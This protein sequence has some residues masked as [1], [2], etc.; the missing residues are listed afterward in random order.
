[1]HLD[2]EG[3]AGLRSL[4]G[5]VA[6]RR[7]VEQKSSASSVGLRGRLM[8]RCKPCCEAGHMLQL[9]G[10]P[11]YCEVFH[12]T[13]IVRHLYANLTVCNVL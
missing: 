10:C 2:S 7:Q 6:R 9:R 12:L 3:Q 5:A 13:Y 4:T 1:M 11:M 8:W